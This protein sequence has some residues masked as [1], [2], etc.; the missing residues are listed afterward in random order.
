MFQHGD[1][2]QIFE[3]GLVVAIQVGVLQHFFVFVTVEVQV[4]DE[5]DAVLRQGAGL[6]GA[7]NIDGAK[8]LNGVKPLDDHFLA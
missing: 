3:S 8:I 7:Q 4:L 5:N 6:I 2:K 1:V